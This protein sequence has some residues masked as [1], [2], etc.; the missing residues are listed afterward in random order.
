MAEKFNVSIIFEAFDRASSVVRGLG[1]ALSGFRS[2]ISEIAKHYE[3]ISGKMYDTGQTMTR[4][5][6]RPLARFGKNIF[7]TAL[8]FETAMNSLQAKMLDI[9]GNIDQTSVDRLRAEAKRLGA[10]TAFTAAQSAKAMKELA[11]SGLNVNEVLTTTSQTLQLAQGGELAMADA[12]RY[13]VNIL[14]SM[15]LRAGDIKKNFGEITKVLAVAANQSTADVSHIA[16]AFTKASGTAR[17]LGLDVYQLGAMFSKMANMGERGTIAGTLLYNAML[18]M[19]NVTP[20]ASKAFKDMGID[21]KD[22]VTEGGKIKDFYGMLSKIAGEVD[23]KSITDASGKLLST[24]ELMAKKTAKV[25]SIFQAFGLRGGRAILALI[26]GGTKGLRKLT[27][28]MKN[29]SKLMER[30]QQTMAKGLP[31]AVFLFKSALDGLM[32]TISESWLGKALE[33]VL[34]KLTKFISYMIENHPQLISFVS[35]ILAIVAAIG[36]LLMVLGFVGGKLST[37][38]IGFSYLG[39]ILFGMGGIVRSIIPIFI[40]LAKT[41]FFASAAMIKF[42]ITTIAAGGPIVWI[43]VA[44]AALVAGIILL[45]RNWDALSNLWSKASLKMKAAIFIVMYPFILFFGWIIQLI[46]VVKLIQKHIDGFADTM[47]ELANKIKSV[48]SSIKDIFFG[49]GEKTASLFKAAWEKAI[50]WLKTSLKAAAIEYVKW[51]SGYKV[52][53]LAKKKISASVSSSSKVDVNIN[54]KSQG[55]SQ[56]TIQS[57]HKTA[58]KNT[59]VKVNNSSMGKT[60]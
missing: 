9:K 35:V 27:D 55:G 22:F 46:Q 25:S 17:G 36:P 21:L 45:Y 26:A 44:I 12:A 57:V 8:D 54:V 52:F 24:Q 51:W 38:F 2:R 5:V 4:N 56:S 28:D 16:S 47:K 23:I 14:N 33:S 59:R 18:K 1:S 20:K 48:G 29:P 39:R 43:I 19:V 53:E 49:I 10:T 13:A 41:I 37:L 40:T 3:K 60:R 6:S 32:L 11:A 58:G 15:G 31:G 42:G 34:R 30:M 7:R 50:V